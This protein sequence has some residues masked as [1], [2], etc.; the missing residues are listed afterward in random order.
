M[1][2]VISHAKRL[3]IN[4]RENR[5][6][7]PRRCLG[8]AVRGPRRGADECAADHEGLAGAA[9]DRGRRQGA[10][11]HL[12]D[13]GSRGGDLVRLEN[14]Q[15]FAGQ[16]L[17]KHTRLCSAITYASVQGLTLRGRVWLYDVESPHF[18]IKHLYMGCSRAHQF[19]TFE[20]F[21]RRRDLPGI[22]AA[23]AER[24]SK[25]SNAS[26]CAP[27]GNFTAFFSL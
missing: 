17:L 15:C 22:K 7:A 26:K 20:R 18:S 12:P 8:G 23:G 25:A 16:E 6:L 10:E 4:D 3:Q 9:I 21:V 14:G 1:S 5:R 24:A 27:R 11:G 13:R 2:L 19:G